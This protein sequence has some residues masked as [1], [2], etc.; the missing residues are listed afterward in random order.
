M[1]P[2]TVVPPTSG[3]IDTRHHIFW[4]DGAIRA[5]PAALPL[6]AST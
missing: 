2:F 1:R 5:G 6:A 4:A 3:I